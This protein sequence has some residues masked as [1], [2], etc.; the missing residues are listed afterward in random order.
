M[1]PTIENYDHHKNDVKHNDM[2]Y[3]ICGILYLMTLT[4]TLTHDITRH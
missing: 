4:L 3:Y 1:S 2:E